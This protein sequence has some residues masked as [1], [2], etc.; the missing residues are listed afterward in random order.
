MKNLLS[1]QE[2][3][4]YTLVEILIDQKDWLQLDILAKALDCS[5]RV[6]IDDIQYLNDQFED[7]SIHTSKQGVKL[8]YHPNRGFK[9]FCQRKLDLSESYRIFEIVFLNHNLS[10]QELADK[11]FFSSS[12]VY[13]L[14]NQINKQTKEAY[15]FQIE[16]NPCR[17]TGNEY[18]IRYIGYL[19]FFEKYSHYEWVFE[20]EQLEELNQF[21]ERFNEMSELRTDFAYFNVFKVIS[22]VNSIRYKQGHNVKFEGE[23]EEF[24]DFILSTG[25]AKKSLKL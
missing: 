16:T 19:Y 9:T 7:F 3:R 12:K 5:T 13:R 6:L 22:G 15:D 24:L 8:T 4:R 20:H 18:N 21:L 17:I 11:L 25:L 2:M 23:N 14:I 1:K 10:V